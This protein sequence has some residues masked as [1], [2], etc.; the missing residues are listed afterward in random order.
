[1]FSAIICDLDGLLSDTEPLHREAYRLTLGGMGI[2]LGDE[3]YARHWIREGKGVKDFLAHR[4]IEADIGA[5]RARKSEEYKRLVAMRAVAMPGARAML[6]RFH[7]R[8][9]LA[10]ASASYADAVEC[11]LNTL[12]FADYFEA[13]VSG[14]EVERA[15]PW[16]DVFLAAAK[17]LGVAPAGCVVLEDSEKGIRAA[18]AAGMAGVAVPNEHTARHDFSLASATVA[19]LNDVTFPLLESIYR[20]HHS[21]QARA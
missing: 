15:K 17:R 6:E 21:E 9:R 5:V 7:G 2:E 16:P 1:M 8:L 14:S 20:R 4:R 18:H 19:S 3:E 11:V 12:G 10:L 13:A